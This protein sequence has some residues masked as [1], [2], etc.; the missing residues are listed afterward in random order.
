M[1][2]LT[3]TTSILCCWLSIYRPERLFEF[4]FPLSRRVPIA[5]NGNLQ[6][7]LVKFADSELLKDALRGCVGDAAG[8]ELHAFVM[9]A[10]HNLND[11]LEGRSV[12][13]PNALNLQYAIV[14]AI[15]SHVRRHELSDHSLNYLLTFAETFPARE[16][17]VL[18]VADL[19][20]MLGERLIHLDI[21]ALGKPAC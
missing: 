20:K 17:G 3:R 1:E 11:V 5:T 12:S 2:W 16:L 6:A 9:N 7:A 14:S 4:G 15:V 18:L 19:F 13:I 21:Y 8:A 10:A